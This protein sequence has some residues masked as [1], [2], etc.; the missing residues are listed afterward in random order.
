MRE[1]L[2]RGRDKND[3]WHEGYYVCLNGNSHRI[4]I[5]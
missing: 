2:Y 5:P 4:Y 1:I 3:A